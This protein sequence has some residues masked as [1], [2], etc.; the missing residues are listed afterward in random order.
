MYSEKFE[1]V[2]ST[3]KDKYYSIDTKIPKRNFKALRQD[4]NNIGIIKFNEHYELYDKELCWLITSTGIKFDRLYL[5]LPEVEKQ[6]TFE[7]FKFNQLTTLFSDIVSIIKSNNLIDIINIIKENSNNDI[8]IL[9]PQA[10]YNT[11][12][13]PYQY[14]TNVVFNLHKD[15]VYTKQ[16]SYYQSCIQYDKHDDTQYYKDTIVTEPSIKNILLPDFYIPAYTIKDDFVFNDKISLESNMYYYFFMHDI[17]IYYIEANNYNGTFNINVHDSELLNLIS[18]ETDQAKIDKWYF[19]YPHYKA[20]ELIVQSID[21]SIDLA[22][23][24]MTAPELIIESIRSLRNH[25]SF[26]IRNIYI[27]DNVLEKEYEHHMVNHAK[28]L[29]LNNTVKILYNNVNQ[30]FEMIPASRFDLNNGGRLGQKLFDQSIDYLTKISDANYLIVCDDKI[31]INDEI[32]F[33]P[34]VIWNG[35]S[36]NNSIDRYLNV[37]N[38]SMMRELNITY[39]TFEEFNKIISKL[40]LETNK[41]SLDNQIILPNDFDKYSSVI[42]RVANTRGQLLYNYLLD[43]Y[44]YRL[45]NYEDYNGGNPEL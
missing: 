36:T 15:I 26:K 25:Y 9:N 28:K 10:V 31:L 43:T 8:Y 7:I 22:F 34:N 39:N 4:H 18:N 24:S 5:I 6:D 1:K 23:V 35:N 20:S 42:F 21:K 19:N 45:I 38:I 16:H 2:Y 37:F 29:P 44:N 40:N 33:N 13:I 17:K 3:F 32:K 30:C 41:V 27:L 14:G 12:N 11:L